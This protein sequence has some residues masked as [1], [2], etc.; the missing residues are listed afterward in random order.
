MGM[1]DSV[2]AQC[3]KCGSPLEFQSKAGPCELKRYSVHSVPPEVAQSVDGDCKQCACG[4]VVT[5][6]LSQPVARAS[7]DVTVSGI[8]DFD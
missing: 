3:P 7:M 2:F 6:K 8:E 1:F 5:I 4:E